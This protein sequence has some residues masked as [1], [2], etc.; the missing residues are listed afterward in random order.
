MIMHRDISMH[1]SEFDKDEPSLIKR[2]NQGDKKAF[3]NIYIKYHIV[4]FDFIMNR[5]HS[6]EVSEE[7]TQNIF[8]KIWQ[9]RESLHPDGNL[10]AY[11]YQCARNAINNYIRHE[12]IK[13]KYLN[14]QESFQSNPM[15]PEKK[16]LNT[17]LKNFLETAISELP[18]KR[19]K[20]F[21]YA[22]EEGLPRKEI[23]ERLGISIKTVEDH[24]WKAL[25]SLR[26]RISEY[27]DS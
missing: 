14:E 27:V 25:K 23:S 8:L 6:I 16:L 21:L 18:T 20:I 13:N 3:E 10:R 12:N 26:Y 9:R 2:I 11:L 5:L 4:L 22:F 17:E 24:L 7:I 19:R 1:I 15:T